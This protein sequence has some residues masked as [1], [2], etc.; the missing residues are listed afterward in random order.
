MRRV[1]VLLGLGVAGISLA[2]VPTAAEAS[3]LRTVGS[4]GGG[5]YTS[6]SDA[7]AD[8]DSG[9]T[10]V[11][12]DQGTYSECLDVDKELTIVGS[13]VSDGRVTVSCATTDTAALSVGAKAR[14]VG[15]GFTHADGRGILVDGTA[16]ELV[17]ADAVVE[18]V[19]ADEGAG[20]YLSGGVVRMQRVVFDGAAATGDGGAIYMDS[21]SMVAVDVSIV[22][23]S[24][25]NG[26]GVAVVGGS[27]Q[28]Q[29][30]SIERSTA[31]GIGGGLYYTSGS[32]LVID[33]GL[34]DGNS[35]VNEGGALYLDSTST[36]RLSDLLLDTNTASSGGAVYS[37]APL[38]LSASLLV[39]NEATTN[40][41]GVVAGAVSAFVDVDFRDNKTT[42]AG[43]G[44]YAEASV[45]TR[46]C[47]FDSNTAKDGAGV[48]TSGAWDDS[49]S[50]FDSN[51]A[52][53]G[54]GG[55]FVNRV[56]GSLYGTTFLNNSAT[57]ADGGGLWID[58][59]TSGGTFN[60]YG[61]TLEDNDA[62]SG[63]GG[64]VYVE[65]DARLTVLGLEAFLNTAETGG[66]VYL[67]D[68]PTSV[69]IDASRIHSNI[70]DY[71]GGLASAADSLDTSTSAMPR[72]HRTRI[73]DNEA[74]VS[75]GGVY[76]EN[77]G[78][79][80]YDG[81]ITSNTADEDGGGLYATH[82][83]WIRLR[84]STVCRNVATSQGGGIA[85]VFPWNYREIYGNVLMENTAKREGGALYAAGYD[86]TSGARRD[87][88][89]YYNSVIGNDSTGTIFD[90]VH[91][92]NTVSTPSQIVSRYGQYGYQSYSH[93]SQA[94]NAS[95]W[96][97]LLDN[98]F[99]GATVP[100]LNNSTYTIG[101]SG[102][103]SANPRWTRYA[104]TDCFDDD[105]RT[106]SYTTFGPQ[107]V[108]TGLGRRHFVDGDGDGVT[109]FEGDC[110]DSNRNMYPGNTEIVGNFVDEDCVEWDD[111]DAD[112]DGYAA[113][114]VGGTDCDDGDAAIYPGATD[115]PYDGIDADCSGGDDDA[116]G[117]GYGNGV[118]CDDTDASVHPDAVESAFDG[119][120]QDCDG[121]DQDLDGDGFIGAFTASDGTLLA[122]PATADTDCDPVDAAI[123]PGATET[124][125]DGVDQDCLGDDDYDQDGDG[126]RS[127]LEDPDGLGGDCDD[128]D[129]TISSLAAET[130][131]DG[132]D[133]NC[134]RLSDY[135]QDYDG[136]DSDAY[137]GGDCEDDNELVYTGAP[138]ILDFEDGEPVDNDCDRKPNPD[139]DGDGVLNWYE[140]EQG[141][142]PRVSDS[143][144]DSIP[145]GVE[146]PD[147]A[148]HAEMLLPDDTDGDGTID[149]LDSDSDD[150]GVP[151]EDEAGVS[152][153]NPRDT[154]G[155]GTPDYRDTDDD[156]DGLDTEV[157]IA[158]GIVDSDGDGL[159]DYL[160]P[161]SDNDGVLDGA[162]RDGDSDGDGIPDR[163]DAGSDWGSDTTPVAASE[164]GFGLGCSSTGA[165]PVGLSL[166]LLPLLVLRRRRGGR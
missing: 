72:I 127:S 130:W 45:S 100:I 146:W 161:D 110:D 94:T 86:T 165:T 54:G 149:A 73:Y 156:D 80:F 97:V 89:F 68:R 128:T 116:D 153:R 65:P 30:L 77:A 60:L 69:L 25:R 105:L 155:D 102:N 48:Y 120:D 51:I 104:S 125:Y 16:A 99:F 8:A 134:D 154:D 37:K 158:D 28:A 13:R 81:W 1:P 157:E 112:D 119:V 57:T 35:A 115:T 5:D 142:D 46:E 103:V 88:I 82:S 63:R 24:A 23:G 43:G 126:D 93:D 79:Q 147:I 40:G 98:V 22:K 140:E 29:D 141:T 111:R 84:G 62:D 21:G 106:T 109:V 66:G 42:E 32:A 124:W 58:A 123:N 143:D 10:I 19:S 27:F 95:T 131:Y 150:D 137:G 55:A 64:G 132:I 164:Y 4:G 6:I 53:E 3:T 76:V 148:T 31:S 152:P 117:D 138:D 12:I 129:P 92:D 36:A 47:T 74:S 50:L 67:G 14:I 108:T 133:Q 166:L 49:D 85:L 17:L 114:A 136:D 71:G 151:D 70:A 118:D 18:S 122:N 34:M 83:N 101:R 139:D 87:L 78:L 145:D 20:L 135:D 61:V 7:I 52:D 2:L 107:A 113:S 59:E 90:G 163:L 11:I 15:L 160:D 121:F 75:G 96:S 44:L 162:E 26:G 9:D 33:G 38:S 41:G 91:N 39:E 144:G 56:S 159:A